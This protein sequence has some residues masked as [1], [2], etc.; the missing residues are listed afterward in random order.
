MSSSVLDEKQRKSCC[1][2]SSWEMCSMPCTPYH[3]S[4]DGAEVGLAGCS[5]DVFTSD[6]HIKKGTMIP[7]I[8]DFW[9]SRNSVFLQRSD[10]VPL[11]APSPTSSC[12]RRDGRLYP[13]ETA[14]SGKC[15]VPQL[16]MC[17]FQ[18]SARWHFQIFGHCVLMVHLHPEHLL[19]E[20]KLFGISDGIPSDCD[21]FYSRGH[22]CFAAQEVPVPAAGIQPA[23]PKAPE[24]MFTYTFPRCGAQ[25]CISMEFPHDSSECN[26][27][28]Q[29]PCKHCRRS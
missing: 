23:M 2:F 26:K 28:K 12:T 15:L 4:V 20:Q 7:H 27:S 5:G 25:L 10:Q 19:C 17:D 1:N 9:K 6:T 16:V 3:T 8:S 18:L 24:S 21:L 14:S 22:G 13:R 29:H 11:V